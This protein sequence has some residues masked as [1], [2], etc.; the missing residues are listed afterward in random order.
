M[1]VLF[2]PKHIEEQIKN[3]TIYFK[4]RNSMDTKIEQL[5]GN[6]INEPLT[7]KS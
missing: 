6:Y 1:C 2:K 5:L 3:I 7:V 4:L